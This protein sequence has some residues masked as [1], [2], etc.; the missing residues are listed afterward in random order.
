MTALT[1]LTDIAYAPVG[2]GPGRGRL[3]D[4]HLPDGAG[5]WPLA[6]WNHGSGWL[7]DN[8]RTG[9][10]E[11]AAELCPSGFAVAGVA[12]RS[13]AQARFPA[14]VDDINAAIDHL[15]A[16]ADRYRID[17][18][19]IGV[20]GESSGGWAATM[21]GLTKGRDDHVKAVVAIY[22]PTD[23]LRMDEQKEA[24]GGEPRNP[25]DPDS[26]I[27]RML[28]GPLRQRTAAAVRASPVTHVGHRSPPF[29][30]LHGLLDRV[31][32]FGQSELL[33]RALADAGRDVQLIAL[34][35]AEHGQWREFFTDPA[36][37][38]GATIVSSRAGATTQPC[39]VDPTWDTVA[40]FLRRH[41][42]D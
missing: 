19:R 38:Q 32:P 3:L 29:L 27:A 21:A 6:I 14:Q 18:D 37:K 26:P 7:A 15:R 36:V 9:T 42:V 12:I 30:I 1:Q 5:P 25:D 10:D 34:P 11:V 13:S 23:L 33:H 4:L 17:P 24:S 40:D 2:A 41:L 8:G 35:H 31:V 28:G 16:H 22:P 39:P 20:L